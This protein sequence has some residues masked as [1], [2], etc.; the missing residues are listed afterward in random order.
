MELCW[1]WI[2]CRV[3]VS[4]GDPPP[5]SPV[6]VSRARMVAGSLGPLDMK[7]HNPVSVIVNPWFVEA[8]LCIVD[9]TY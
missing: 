9:K 8:V 6:P 7:R 2:S 3:C 4:L 1:A 5:Y